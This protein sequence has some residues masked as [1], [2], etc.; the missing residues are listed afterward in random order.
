[1]SVDFKLICEILNKWPYSKWE[2]H[3]QFEREIFFHKFHMK[4][5][6]FE[7]FSF[8]YTKIYRRFRCTV[9]VRDL[10]F[11]WLT[12]SLLFCFVHSI[13]SQFLFCWKICLWNS[14]ADTTL[15]AIKFN[16]KIIVSWHSF[17]FCFLPFILL[18]SPCF[19]FYGEK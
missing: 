4:I 17:F 1:M 19:F 9:F 12:T 11:L 13:F 7:V 6:F 15:T 2:S 10:F 5:E 3:N 16:V 18:F 8:E 14:F